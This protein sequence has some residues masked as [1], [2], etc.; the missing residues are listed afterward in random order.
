MVDYKL[1]NIL[2]FLFLLSI[3]NLKV[4][5]QET[6]AHRL[7][8][9]ANF[10]HLHDFGNEVYVD[11][12]F[13]LKRI[14]VDSLSFEDVE[15]ELPKF[16]SISN[17]VYFVD[18]Q[19]LSDSLLYY[20]KENRIVFNKFSQSYTF[21]E[22]IDFREAYYFTD[23]ETIYTFNQAKDQLYKSIDQAKTF[24]PI[25][26]IESSNFHF[27]SDTLFVL[28]KSGDLFVSEDGGQQWLLKSNIGSSE[29]LY[30]SG[31]RLFRLQETSLMVSDDLGGSWNLS[32]EVTSDIDNFYNSI[33]FKVTLSGKGAFSYGRQLFTTIDGGLTWKLNSYLPL[34]SQ[35]PNQFE[36]VEGDKLI[37]QNFGSNS[38]NSLWVYDFDEDSWKSFTKQ[39]FGTLS[40]IR[41]LEETESYYA[42]DIL[43]DWVDT[44]QVK[45]SSDGG[46]T[47]E[48]LFQIK[49][50]KLG[51]LVSWE[52]V[53]EDN[54]YFYRYGTQDLVKS[55]NQGQT[56]EVKYLNEN[57]KASFFHIPNEGEIYFYSVCD[58][59][60]AYS[61]DDGISW[62]SLFIPNPDLVIDAVIPSKTSFGLGYIIAVNPDNK[63]RFVFYYEGF[64]I[65]HSQST[66]E[67]NLFPNSALLNSDNQLF[68]DTW[69][70]YRYD[71]KNNVLTKL[72]ESEDLMT[73]AGIDEVDALWFSK[74]GLSFLV[75]G[76]DAE[77]F[78]TCLLYASP[79]PRD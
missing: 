54:I 75:T 33:N 7:F 3:L 1:K 6:M 45:R 40:N 39:H 8:P 78:D 72:T 32:F 73:L 42:V 44:M 53:D 70:T 58:N 18:I 15:Y 34:L 79:S 31:S 65:L 26:E 41:Y 67:F 63:E 76:S 22:N 19:D 48:E 4:N 27:Y 16:D 35:A 37:L 61:I 69:S 46:Y 71:G 74:I 14:N 52:I 77:N 12:D 62:D 13:G 49:D 57:G 2:F 59:F 50:A 24:E 55:E 28:G 43:H 21:I 47:W 38:I 20:K 68:F 10:Q 5:A 9:Y 29:I 23:E 17:T 60:M 56:W 25:L 36:F 11:N 66:G 30:Y 51:F 64:E